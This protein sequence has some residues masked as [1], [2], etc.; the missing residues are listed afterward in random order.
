MFIYYLFFSLII[1]FFTFLENVSKKFKHGMFL[2]FFLIFVFISIRYDF[3]NDYSMYLNEFHKLNTIDDLK[4][5]GG[6]DRLEPGWIFINRAFKNI[7]FFP[8]IAIWSL[9]YC[10]I[11]YNFLRYSLEKKYLFLSVLFF[12]ISSGVFLV[13]L[14]AL[15]QTLALLFFLFSF[16]FI[17]KRNIIFYFITIYLAS[18][19]HSSALLLLPL[20]FL[21]WMKVNN[22]LSFIYFA[23][24]IILFFI[25]DQFSDIINQIILIINPSYS[26][27]LKDDNNVKVVIGSGIGLLFSTLNFFFLLFY[28]DKLDESNKY[29]QIAYKCVI[30]FY[31]LS[32]LTLSIGM[33][34]RVNFYFSFFQIITVPFI[35]SVIR[36]RNLK[37]IYLTLNLFF[38]IYSLY[39]FFNSD[40]FK[41]KYN[42][43][44]TIFSTEAVD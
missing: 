17:V 28:N 21:N 43:Y 22:K 24:Y 2:S 13:Q 3:G 40:I 41:D 26:Y 10:L 38:S 39:N 1:T 30:I 16:R 20:Y 34:G 32:P 19:L 9:F 6:L 11:M 15:R 8:L 27:Y 7:G 31:I 25:G 23:A 33:I 37:I 4:G 29:I 14:S 44:K 5:Y 18:L 36:I 35:Y 12:L 42:D